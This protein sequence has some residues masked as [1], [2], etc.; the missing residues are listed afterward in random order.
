M[1]HETVETLI[2]P[3]R[4]GGL[5]C[6][7]KI[8]RSL[9]DHRDGTTYSRR[10][11]DQIM[12]GP[13]LLPASRLGQDVGCA[14]PR[15]AAL[16]ALVDLKIV[17]KHA[18]ATRL[19]RRSVHSP[20]RSR[21]LTRETCTYG[22]RICPDLEPAGAGAG[23]EDEAAGR[24]SDVPR[25]ARPRTAVLYQCFAVPRPSPAS[26]ARPPAL[27]PACRFHQPCM[28]YH[29]CTV[30]RKPKKKDHA[31]CYSEEQGAKARARRVLDM[32]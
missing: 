16:C 3:C 19:W 29:V 4:T 5:H 18:R 28:M 15:R 27:L 25:H 26:L 12:G 24:E 21:S 6:R 31:T 8:C 1:P 2:E 17:Q 13:S 14:T 20:A 10:L 23:M 7:D 22:R 11:P 32:R 9:G 30:L